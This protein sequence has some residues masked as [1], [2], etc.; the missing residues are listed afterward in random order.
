MRYQEIEVTPT[1]AKYWLENNRV[2]RGIS[3]DRVNAYVRE[4]LDGNW[5]L[6]GESIK[7]GEDGT[8]KDGQHRLSAVVKANVPVKMLVVFDIPESINFFDRGRTR[9]VCDTLRIN[10]MQPPLSSSLSVAVAKLA[11][12]LKGYGNVVTEHEVSEWLYE[13]EDEIKSLFS[14]ALYKTKNQGINIKQSSIVLASI[15]ALKAG[16]PIEKVSGFLNTVRTGLY[17]GESETAAVVFRNDMIS[18]AQKFK[19]RTDQIRLCFMA[20]KAISDYVNGKERHQSYAKYKEKPTF[21]TDYWY[22]KETA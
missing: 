14:N 9:S 22:G 5:I 8:L 3:K 10:G 15:F 21:E 16:I 1:M 6:N 17:S 4:I 13:H 20:E 7:I 12:Y 19:S 2:N 11:L 18:Y